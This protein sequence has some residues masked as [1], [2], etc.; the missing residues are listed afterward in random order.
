MRF[1]CRAIAM[2]LMLSPAFFAHAQAT[3]PA[4]SAVRAVNPQNLPKPNGY[5]H[6]IE[7]H[8][9]RTLYV[10]GQLPL[11]KDGNLVGEG[12][13]AVQAEQV[14]ANLKTALEASG[15]TFKDVVKLNMFVTDMGQLKPLRVARD[16]YIDLKNPPAST[17]VEVKRFVVQGAMVEIDAVAVVP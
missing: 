8:G 7:A 4:G 3:E 17:L 2:A 12:D 10:S 1:V 15:A 11:N 13:F 14:F 16:K 9:G 6:A 5:S